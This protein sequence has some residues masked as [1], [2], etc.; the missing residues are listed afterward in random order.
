ML[1]L[2]KVGLA[3]LIVGFVAATFGAALETALSTGYSISQ[4]LGWQW[5]KYVAP[6]NAAR[7]HAVVLTAII[8]G[9]MRSSP[10]STR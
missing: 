9:S 6:R 5:G 4:Y 2:G 7:F 10:L 8:V 1:A 3:F